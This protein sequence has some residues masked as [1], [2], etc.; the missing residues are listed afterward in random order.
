MKLNVFSMSM[1]VYFRYKIKNQLENAVKIKDH[2]KFGKVS[3]TT[4]IITKKRMHTL[5]TLKS[6]AKS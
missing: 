5:R 4:L 3:G 2:D 6:N 1:I